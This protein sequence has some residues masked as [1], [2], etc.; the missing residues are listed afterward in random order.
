[1]LPAGAEAKALADV[2]RKLAVL[3][4]VLAEEPAERSV[5]QWLTRS[6]DPGAFQQTLLRVLHETPES[7]KKGCA[8]IGR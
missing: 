4:D 1:M 8:N 6:D 7:E 2:A 3:L 5:M